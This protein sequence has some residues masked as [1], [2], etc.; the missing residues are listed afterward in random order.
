M[1]RSDG[2]N[3]G[4][5]ETVQIQEGAPSGAARF[6]GA[7]FV[8]ALLAFV[9]VGIDY[10]NIVFTTSTR[11]VFLAVLVVSLI[12]YGELFTAF[13]SRFAPFLL[14]YLLWCFLTGMWSDVPLL[15][16]LKATAL[17]IV[18]TAFIGGG[19]AWVKRLQPKFP[20]FFSLSVVG[21]ALFAGISQHGAPIKLANGVE[22]YQGLSG[23]PNYLG[24]LTA[25]ALPL[26]MYQTYLAWRRDA[27]RMKM[28][29]WLA[30]TTAVAVL[31]W[32]S[33]SRAS[34][35]CGVMIVGIFALVATPCR[36]AATAISLIFV[37]GVVA[38]AAPEL[39]LGVYQRVVVKGSRG[40]DAFV[41]RR[42]TWQTT[43]EATQQGGAL[44][45]GYGVSAGFR[46]YSLGLTSNT[47]GREKGNS[48]L[49]VWE[50]T[51]LVGVA[52]Y[53]IFLFALFQDLLTGL[54]R[55]PDI[56][57]RVQ[58][59][60]LIGLI[61]GLLGQSVFEAWWT[62]PGSLESSVFWS[63]VGVAT[64]LANRYATGPAASQAILTERELPV[65]RQIAR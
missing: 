48:Q 8:V 19:D 46:D 57:E 39:E 58:L 35:L 65:A 26:P 10:L 25:A 56:E 30:V 62:S 20:L 54:A 3:L 13:R 64:A 14:M 53:A 24:I 9:G 29:L 28:L 23:N 37:L 33:G 11:W 52:L 2:V 61:A 31:L 60:L 17:F 21:A 47:Y 59:A 51:G 5:S 16:M 44:G 27:G 36:R 38:I 18:V 22:I 1:Q 43:Y 63:A 34:L 42:T 4:M 32:R 6:R 50:E 15:S 49:A 45:L 7:I 41:S 12:P 55:A 40:E